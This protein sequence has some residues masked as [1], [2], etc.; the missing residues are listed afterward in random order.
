MRNQRQKTGRQVLEAIPLGCISQFT[1]KKISEIFGVI[2]STVSVILSAKYS[3]PMT[4]NRPAEI[5]EMDI[6]CEGAWISSQE[7][8]FIINHKKETI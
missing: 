1:N 4:F 5:D 3:E 6:E 7:R 2:E 8:Q